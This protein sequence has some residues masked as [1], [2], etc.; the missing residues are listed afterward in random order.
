MTKEEYEERQRRLDE[1]IEDARLT[2][3]RARARFDQLCDDARALRVEWQEQQ[4][5]ATTKDGK[6]AN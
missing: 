5:K 1:D 4:R 6:P 3:N 2:L